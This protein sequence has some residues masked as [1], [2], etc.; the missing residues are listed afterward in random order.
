MRSWEMAE[1]ELGL[2][3]AVSVNILLLR[4]S[5]GF[6]RP[7]TARRSILKKSSSNTWR[8]ERY[9]HA[10]AVGDLSRVG[11]VLQLK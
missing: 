1:G 11:T 4:N 8:K 10:L 5:C 3:K 7:K 6:N 2:R 9:I